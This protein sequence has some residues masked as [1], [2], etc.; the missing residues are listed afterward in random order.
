MINGVLRFIENRSF[1][2]FSKVI[3][4]RSS[5]IMKID[6]KVIKFT[7]TVKYLG[8]IIDKKL[9]FKQHIKDKIE[10]ATNNLSYLRRLSA[11]N[12]GLTPVLSNLMY[13]SVIEPSLLYC[14]T[15]F[16][17]RT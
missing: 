17:H 6:K 5:G 15:I 9:T 4:S 2:W 13:T 3:L 14:S 16:S 7:E 1:K 12:Y 8:L 10:K 11:S